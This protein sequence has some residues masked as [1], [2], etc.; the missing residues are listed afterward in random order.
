LRRYFFEQRG[1]V[2]A[3]LNKLT[4]KSSGRREAKAF[5][6]VF[7]EGAE[8]ADLLGR[9][10]PLLGGR[11]G[12]WRGTA[13]LR[14]SALSDFKVPPSEAI[15]FLNLRENKITGV[16]AETF[17]QLKDTWQEAL[18]KG[19]TMDQ[20]IDRTKKVYNDA[21]D[22]RAEPLRSLKPTRR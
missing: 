19:E 5:E 9:M 13:Y 1:R 21:T 18:S 2:L 6:D 7:N 14:R 10:K 12:I 8:N 11:P 16:N 15:H 3:N 20:I 22:H 4:K 17:Q